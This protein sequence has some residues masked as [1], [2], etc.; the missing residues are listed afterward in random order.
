MEAANHMNY[1]ALQQN[2]FGKQAIIGQG[3][4]E[5]NETNPERTIDD[6]KIYLNGKHKLPES[7]NVEELFHIGKIY[8]PYAMS[9]MPDTGA[10]II[11][12][13][14]ISKECYMTIVR[15]KLD[16]DLNGES[17]HAI[18]AMAVIKR[19]ELPEGFDDN[20][21]IHGLICKEMI[22]LHFDRL[23][24]FIENKESLSEWEFEGDFINEILDAHF[25]QKE[26]N[27]PMGNELNIKTR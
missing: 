25:E 24:E 3:F 23:L 1:M 8:H 17:E 12:E 22:L 26:F 21:S 7:G 15:L 2:I 5:G 20:E 6:F 9:G 14:G 4:S 13:L 27:R 16:E 18:D 11:Y 10:E 19:T